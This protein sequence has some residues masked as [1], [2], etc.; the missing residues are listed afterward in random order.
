MSFDCFPWADGLLS[1]SSHRFLYHLYY[2]HSSYLHPYRS[3]QFYHYSLHFSSAKLI[4]PHSWQIYE[5]NLV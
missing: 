4:L 3:F 1:S 5:H 2:T